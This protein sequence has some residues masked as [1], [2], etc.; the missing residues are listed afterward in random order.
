MKNL[1]AVYRALEVFDRGGRHA[2]TSALARQMR[3]SYPKAKKLLE[4]WQEYGL[5]RSYRQAWRR[6]VVA[7]FWS[8]TPA[9]LRVIL[10]L[11]KARR[12]NG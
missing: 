9:M 10:E 2:S 4:E 3:V 7:T 5:V 1:F 8:P 6:N 12:N 11:T